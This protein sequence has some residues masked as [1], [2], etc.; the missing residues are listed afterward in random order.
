M[1]KPKDDFFAE[2]DDLLDTMN[3]EDDASALVLREF[4]A[5][6]S[7]GM[8]PAFSKPAVL[9]YKFP[10]LLSMSSDE[11]DND[12]LNREL[13][14]LSRPRCSVTGK[15]VSYLS[16]RER[17]CQINLTM[18]SH[19]VRPPFFRHSRKS[20]PGTTKDPSLKILSKDRMIID[21][22]W[23]HSNGYRRELDDLNFRDLMIH[24]NFNFSL[25]E[26]FVTKAWKTDLRVTK[27]LL[28]TDVEQW[29]MGVL[30]ASDVRNKVQR[31]GNEARDINQSLRSIAQR[32]RKLLPEHVESFTQLWL[33]DQ[34]CDGGPQSLIALVNAWQNGTVPLTKS[35][36]SAKL[37]KMRR[38][39]TST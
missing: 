17:V 29:Q 39:T 5:A 34:L 38:W 1:N 33:A 35:T 12:L 36:M 8:S 16:V 6:P 30:R 32:T 31:L 14:S 7:S 37:K 19:C 2:L 18:N 15:L 10:I 25:A 22:H 3:A 20:P 23:L 11:P 13:D 26:Q 27:I 4:D 28:L 21:L 9:G 24:D